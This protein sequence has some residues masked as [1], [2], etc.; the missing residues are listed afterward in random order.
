MDYLTKLYSV[1]DGAEDDF[2]EMQKKVRD[3][4]KKKGYAHHWVTDE[5]DAP[6]SRAPQPA[7]RRTRPGVMKHKGGMMKI[8]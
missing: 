6:P 1:F 2:L 7:R 8:N 3:E 4:Y 5:D